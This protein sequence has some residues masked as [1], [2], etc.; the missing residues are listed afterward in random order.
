MSVIILYFDGYVHIFLRLSSVLGQT[1]RSDISWVPRK[2]D[3]VYCLLGERSGREVE[4]GVYGKSSSAIS[5]Q[6]SALGVLESRLWE[7]APA[8]ALY[9]P[10]T[11]RGWSTYQFYCWESSDTMSEGGER[12]GHQD[13]QTF[14]WEIYLKNPADLSESVPLASVSLIQN[15]VKSI[16]QAWIMTQSAWLSSYYYFRA[17]K[18]TML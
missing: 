2:H 9:D 3:G 1:Y 11:H 14:E 6:W 13:G 16:F 17:G 7:L 18:H 8:C 12:K 4:G 10:V 15:Y 5:G